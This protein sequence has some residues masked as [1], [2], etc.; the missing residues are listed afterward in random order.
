MYTWKHVI[1][2]LA[3][4]GPHG[5]VRVPVHQMQHPRAAGL[6]QTFG[7]PCG[8]RASYRARLSNGWLL[9]IEQFEATYEARVER[10][11]AI[12]RRRR[13]RPP[14]DALG[15]PVALGA[16]LGLALGGDT[17]S[18]LTGALLGGMSGL[19]A[20]AA[21]EA[22]DPSRAA[23]DFATV[24]ARVLETSIDA[25]AQRLPSARRRRRSV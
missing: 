9:C 16:L 4:A 20:I 5:V 14:A 12:R 25:T 13:P 7:T 24:L 3:N 6:R 18:A 17:R 23:L 15:G 21:N 8:Q 1:A 11:Q 10:R 22:S 19:G 2:T